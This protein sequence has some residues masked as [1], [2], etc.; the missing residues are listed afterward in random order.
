M[1]ILF[2]SNRIIEKS[3]KQKQ[4]FSDKPSSSVKIKCYSAL[5]VFMIVLFG[6][7]LYHSL[8]QVAAVNVFF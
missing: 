4:Y 8:S 5:L 7:N 2:S 3:I 6:V 1:A